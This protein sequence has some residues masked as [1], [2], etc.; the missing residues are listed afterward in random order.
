MIVVKCANLTIWLN[1]NW[2]GI[3]QVKLVVWVLIQIYLNVIMVQNII[4]VG[5]NLVCVISNDF[6]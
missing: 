3:N 6:W 1:P 4:G 2:L 5:Y